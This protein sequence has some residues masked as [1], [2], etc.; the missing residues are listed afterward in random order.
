MNLD[1]IFMY[2][3]PKDN[4]TERY[5]EIRAKA[6]ELANLILSNTPS[7]REQSL[8][9]TKLQESVMWANASIACN[10]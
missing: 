9:I 8:A 7:S 3:A 5:E 2:H 1:N 4:Q 10:E 6:K